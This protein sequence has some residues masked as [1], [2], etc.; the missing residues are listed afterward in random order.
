MYQPAISDTANHAST[1]CQ[2]RTD[3]SGGGE[4]ESSVPE[5]CSLESVCGQACVYRHIARCIF[6]TIFISH[7]HSCSGVFNFSAKTIAS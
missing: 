2:A 7:K 4:K 5:V 6:T 1:R 3:V